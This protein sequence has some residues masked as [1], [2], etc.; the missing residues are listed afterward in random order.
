M[1]RIPRCQVRIGSAN[2]FDHQTH[3]TSMQSKHN[4]VCIMKTNV[5]ENPPSNK[6]ELVACIKSIKANIDKNAC[7]HCV[8][9]M[10]DRFFIVIKANRNAT[11]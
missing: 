5:L 11:K 6:T 1:H 10:Q 8:Y 7:K 2:V 4:G 3:Q 9:S